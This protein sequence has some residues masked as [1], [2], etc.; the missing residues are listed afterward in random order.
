MSLPSQAMPA[1][2]R[3]HW[4][5]TPTRSSAVWLGRTLV[6][7]ADRAT[8]RPVARFGGRLA[9]GPGVR[10]ATSWD[11]AT[12]SPSAMGSPCGDALSGETV[13]LGGSLLYTLLRR[14]VRRRL[15]ACLVKV[16]EWLQ[17]GR[18]T[19]CVIVRGRS[20]DNLTWGLF[21]GPAGIEPATFGLKVRCSTD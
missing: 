16:A 17:S 15:T 7:P 20:D 3:T 5:A 8:D 13:C 10:A 4:Q 6:G 21:V 9:P 19:P 14:N 18:S 2:Y 12:G 1:G 11:G